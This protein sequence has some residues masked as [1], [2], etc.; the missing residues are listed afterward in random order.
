MATATT[1]LTPRQKE[2]KALLDKDFTPTEV[3][4]KLGVSSNAIYQHLRRMKKAPKAS[5][6][7]TSPRKP[8]TRRAAAR[9]RPSRAKRTTA[10]APALGERGT[11]VLASGT[12]LK[13]HTP[14]Q[15]IR[16]RKD[17]IE[18]AVKHS[19]AVVAEDEKGYLT[20]KERHE[21]LVT[22]NKE[23]LRRLDIA[24]QALQGKI[25]KPAPK[26]QRPAASTNGQPPVPPPAPEPNARP[27]AKP[28]PTPAP[29][30]T[31]PPKSDP[32][33]APEVAHRAVPPN[34]SQAVADQDAGAE[35]SQE[36]EDAFVGE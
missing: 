26:R 35:F 21:T 1:D 7:R 32:T 30:A 9:K 34:G 16:N 15:V 36:G 18:A 11:A 2:I 23:E 8:G 5:K 6:A 12:L 28:E 22:K 3:A 17:E 4:D 14:L 25:V 13:P 20:S 29:V 31:V 10:R 27:D 33:P 19:A 24:E